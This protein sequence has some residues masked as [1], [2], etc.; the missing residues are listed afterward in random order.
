M[1]IL[2]I[3]LCSQFNEDLTYQENLLIKYHLK[4]GHEVSVITTTLSLSSDAV[5]ERVASGYF[6][7]DKGFDIYR[8]KALSPKKLRRFEKLSDTIKRIAPDFIFMHGTQFL[9]ALKVVRYAKRNH[10]TLVADNHADYYNSANSWF[11]MQVLHKGLWRFTTQAVVK[12]SDVIFGVSPIRCDFLND[13][14]GV[15]KR[16]IQLLPL[17]ADDE[18]IQDVRKNLNQGETRGK[19]QGDK[20]IITTGG[21]IDSKKNFIFLARAVDALIKKGLA[22]ELIVFGTISSDVESLLVDENLIESMT[23][24][25]WIGPREMYELFLNSDLN[26]FIGGHSVLWEQA[27]ACAKPTI[28]N[29][30]DGMEHIN[31]NQNAVLVV[32]PL[33]VPELIGTIERF[34]IDKPY[35]DQVHKNSITAAQYFSYS[36]I[37]EK[38]ILK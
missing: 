34:V 7:S 16:K 33:N 10:V 37:A 11:S 9:D 36:Q 21:K 8:L 35:Y 18:L 24:V 19:M 27:V 20:F 1:K 13:V 31:V 6:K 30:I 5:E 3:C 4:F 17:G 29:R 12:C 38:A 28:F 14:Y 15:P 2:H 23:F 26:I 22:I 32:D 25:G